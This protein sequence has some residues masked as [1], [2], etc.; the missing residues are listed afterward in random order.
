MVL[1]QNT[2]IEQRKREAAERARQQEQTVQNQQRID[3]GRE[4]VASAHAQAMLGNAST[5]AD[6]CDVPSRAFPSGLHYYSTF[7]PA[8]SAL[9]FFCRAQALT[10][11]GTLRIEFGDSDDRYTVAHRETFTFDGTPKRTQRDFAKLLVTTV[12][13]FLGSSIG[14]GSFRSVVPLSNGGLPVESPE[15]QK[16]IYSAPMRLV[17]EGID[18]MGSKFSLTGFYTPTW[19]AVAGWLRGSGKALELP[20]STG[21]VRGGDR[22][23]NIALPW[24]FTGMTLHSDD[25]ALRHTADE[26]KKAIGT[27]YAAFQGKPGTALSNRPGAYTDLSNSIIVEEGTVDKAGRLCGPPRQVP[28]PGGGFEMSPPLGCRESDGA[29][30]FLKISYAPNGGGP[31]DP[32]NGTVDFKKLVKEIADRFDAEQK[33]SL[34]AK[35]KQNAVF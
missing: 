25:A 7:H 35:K 8:D 32:A 17:F 10:G 26:V 18:V 19:G 22:S 21:V 34:E 14:R 29:R 20:I 30:S 15:G 11:S 6:N 2:L 9:D 13:T 28:I 5:F 16:K 24:T 33:K 31:L 23:T 3:S 4:A 27:K 12:Q 1:G